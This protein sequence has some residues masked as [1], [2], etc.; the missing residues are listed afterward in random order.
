MS[1]FFRYFLYIHFIWYSENSKNPPSTLLPYRTTPVSWP[2]HSPVLR[3]IKFAIPRGLYSHW[4]PIRPSATYAARDTSSGVLLSSYCSYTYRFADPFS[5][6]C[7][8]STSSIGGPVFH[9]IDDCEHPFLYLPGTGIASYETAITWSLQLN[10]SGIWN[11]VWVWWL[12]MGWIPAWGSL[13]IVHPFI[14]APFFVSVTPFMGILF[15]ILRSNEVF[16]HW[17]SLFLIFL[18]FANCIL[19]VLCYWAY[20]HLSVS[21]YLMTSFVIGLPH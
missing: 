17:S 11:S 19:G 4:W 18:Y 12:I 14:L 7:T 5:S 21:S 8:F 3:Y 16:T 2:S 15:P 10:L 1:V 6:M 9:P 20:I 13:G